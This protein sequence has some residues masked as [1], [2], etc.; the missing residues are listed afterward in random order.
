MLGF[1][2]DPNENPVEAAVDLNAGATGDP[3]ENGDGD[4]ADDDEDPNEKHDI[5]SLSS[6]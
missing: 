2:D 6:A 3:N 1:E 4:E 5:F